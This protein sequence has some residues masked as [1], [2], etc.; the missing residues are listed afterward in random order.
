MYVQAIYTGPLLVCL[1]FNRQYML[2]F[3]YGHLEV[4]YSRDFNFDIK[5]ALSK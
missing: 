4:I 3:G 2:L 1:A 5:E